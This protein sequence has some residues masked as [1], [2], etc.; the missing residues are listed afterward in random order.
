MTLNFE[1][2]YR[3]SNFSVLCFYLN[4]A[5]TEQIYIDNNLKLFEKQ[6]AKA[7]HILDERISNNIDHEAHKQQIDEA[8]KKIN[9]LEGKIRQLESRIPK[10]FPDVKF[11]NY[12]ERKRILVNITYKL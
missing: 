1:V 5:Q 11:L 8:A 10:Q 4:W 12:R 6:D 9:R 7:E 2:I 3:C